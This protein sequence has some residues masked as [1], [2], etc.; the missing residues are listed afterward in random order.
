MLGNG[1]EPTT[2][3]RFCE[4]RHRLDFAWP[5]QRVGVEIQGGVWSRGKHG[6][7]SDIEADNRKGNLLALH[8]WRVLRYSVKDLTERPADVVEE[9]VQALDGKGVGDG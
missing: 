5:D 7:G 1:M 9:V 3:H 2:E 6:R 8:G 4:T